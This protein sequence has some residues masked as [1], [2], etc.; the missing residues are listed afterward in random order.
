MAAKKEHTI[1]AGNLNCYTRLI[2]TIPEIEFKGK[3]MPYTSYQGHMFSFINDEGVVALRLPK[4]EKELFLK[5]YKTSLMVAH[6]TT[7]QEY[8]RIPE[9]VLQKTEELKKYLI[10]SL[11]YVRSLKPKTTRKPQAK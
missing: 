7:L 8:V 10:L 1:P 2:S 9:N 5:Q 4:N 11:D 6:G 3:S